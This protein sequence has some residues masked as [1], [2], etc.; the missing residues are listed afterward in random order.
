MT[1]TKKAEMT[2]PSEALRAWF[3][4][5]RAENAELIERLLLEAL[6]DHIFWRRNYHP[7]DRLTIREG[8]KRTAG[9]EEAV[10]T[11]TQELMGL[12]AELKQG[13]P[14]FSGRYKGHMSFEQTIASQIGYFAAMLYNPNNVAIEASPT[15]TRLE[16]EVANQLARMIGY[17]ATRAWGH[18]TSGGTVANF[19]ALWVARN[20]I[21][22]PIAARGAADQLG[23]TLDVELPSGES[24]PLRS[25][26]LWELLNITNHAALDLWERLWSSAPRIDV[27]SALHAHSLQTLGYQRYTRRLAAAFG[28]PLEPGVVLVAA[29]AHYSWEKIVR[30]LGIGSNQLIFVPV[31]AYY[32][33]NT[34]ALWDAI[35]DLTARQV[36]IQACISVCGTTEESAVDHLHEVVE[37]RR[38]AE[39]ELGVAFHLHSDACYG[40]YSASVTWDAEG[41]RRS[42]ADIRASTG[43]DWPSEAW[44][45]SMAALAE[46]DSVT[47]DP[48]K[49]G[50][51]PYPAGAIV[52]RDRR[53]RELVAID[54]PYLLPS[55]GLTSAEDL[56]LGRFIFEGSKPGASAASVWLSHKVL[57]LDERGYGYLIERTVVGA[58]R[59]HRALANADLLPFRIVLLP[60]PDINIVCYVIT[61]PQL[62][63]L[64]ALNAFNERIYGR[65]S[66]SEPGANPEYII[67]R[68]RFQPPMYEGAMDALLEQVGSSVEEWRAGGAD[69]LVV[70]RSTVM[71][72]FLAEPSGPD[73]ISGFIAALKRACVASL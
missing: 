4:G 62:D 71:D 52:L 37:V 58:R 47:I 29:T 16:L 13:V 27:Q 33:L 55:Q 51:V 2:N 11:L 34:A 60:E 1:E 26:G 72:P 46:T 6:R 73:H 56:V 68:T 40:G 53:A 63:T 30:A 39:R 61:H 24:A 18:L 9:Y 44:V 59:M 36:P 21:Y 12:L 45:A 23:I 50:Y 65:M 54:P 17:D 64:A 31:D 43:T 57:P 69:G 28:D 49:L 70:L 20:I 67:T 10:G 5:P 32:R 8:E 35:R 48:H 14:F 25:L 22:L 66:L 7:E 42:A 38:R 41:N 3:I 19:E 15:T